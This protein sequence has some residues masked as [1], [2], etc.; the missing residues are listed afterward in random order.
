MW[1]WSAT[2][3][4]PHI[5]GDSPQIR[6]TFP[7]PHHGVTREGRQPAR[8][9]SFLPSS[10]QDEAN[11]DD[12]DLIT[13]SKRRCWRRLE[14]SGISFI[15][16]V[17]EKRRG[18]GEIERRKGGTREGRRRV[19]GGRGGGKERGG[20]GGGGGGDL[21]ETIWHQSDSY[22]VFLTPE[23]FSSEFLSYSRC[24][25]VA[26]IYIKFVKVLKCKMFQPKTSGT[27]RIS[28]RRLL[29]HKGRM[30][31]RY[32]SYY[33][34]LKTMNVSRVQHTSHF[35]FP[36]Y[37]ICYFAYF[38]PWTSD[39]QLIKYIDRIDT[40]LPKIQSTVSTWQLKTKYTSLKHKTPK[41]HN[42]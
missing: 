2:R 20:G 5:Q 28:F 36:K 11:H 37:S 17:G 15:T 29:L 33:S 6:F 25:F 30:L 8:E 4:R 34:Y 1:R 41:T 14:W 12:T 22:T 7:P 3:H 19:G 10:R 24:I 18:R 27:H 39:M 9:A 13:N 26:V 16:L 40:F 23:T 35:L 32:K 38:T 21:K 42:T 31:M